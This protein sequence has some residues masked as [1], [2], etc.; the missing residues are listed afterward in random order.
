MTLL[1]VPEGF[2]TGGSGLAGSGAHGEPSIEDL[3]NSIISNPVIEFTVSNRETKL[4]NFIASADFDL[5][6]DAANGISPSKGTAKIMFDS[7]NDFGTLSVAAPALGYATILDVAQII[8]ATGNAFE[9]VDFLAGHHWNGAPSSF[10]S[11]KI[12]NWRFNAADGEPVINTEDAGFGRPDTGLS[13]RLLIY[14]KGAHRMLS[15]T[16]FPFIRVHSDASGIAGLARA[17]RVQWLSAS[18]VV[19][20]N[21]GRFRL[22]H[23][24]GKAELTVADMVILENPGD[25]VFEAQ[26]MLPSGGLSWQPE[27]QNDINEYRVA[28]DFF[29]GMRMMPEPADGGFVTSDQVAEYFKL[30]RLTDNEILT[31][32]M[33]FTTGPDTITGADFSD[34]KTGDTFVISG[35]VSNNG[36]LTALADGDGTSITT[37]ETLTPEGPVSTSFILTALTLTMPR[38]H[39]RPGD[40]IGGFNY[41]AT[42]NF[43]I[44]PGTATLIGTAAVTPGSAF[45]CVVTQGK[46]T[47]GGSKEAAQEW[48]RIL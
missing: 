1:D 15:G 10:E 27:N 36:T 29:A 43:T 14:N 48:T 20:A 39:G 16:A 3:L 38:V 31:T 2:G 46:N 23:Q 19:L 24:G 37:V 42:N 21:D 9:T 32:S 8:F 7:G 18:S 17:A 11:Q 47:I 6:L 13:S 44:D 33:T 35:T 22:E 4:N 34:I 30:H 41:G 26:A 12:V 28:P 25:G 45:L 40:L 5:A